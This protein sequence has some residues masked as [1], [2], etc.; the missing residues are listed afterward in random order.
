[1]LRRRLP[2]LDQVGDVADRVQLLHRLGIYAGMNLVGDSAS[3]NVIAFGF[4]EAWELNPSGAGSWTQ[5]T[6][7]RAPPDGLL[8]PNVPPNSL[9]SCDV[10][11]FG[12]VVYIDGLRT[13]KPKC[14]MW[15][16]KSARAGVNVAAA[17]NYQGQWWNAPAGSEAGWGINFAHQGDVIFATWFTHDANGNAWYMSM[18]AVETGAGTFAGTLYQTTGPRLDA[19]SFDPNQVQRIEVGNGTLAFSDGNNGTFD[20][21]VNGI[22]QTKPITRQVFGPV[23]TCTWAG[24]ANPALATNYQDLWWA[25][26]GVE[27]GWGIN[28][29]HQGDVIFATWFTYDFNGAALPLSATL[30]KVGPGVYSGTL[31]KTAGPPFSSV[32]FDSSAVTR[33]EVGTA[34]V[35][36]SN[37]DAATFSYQV[38]LGGQSASGTRAIERQVFRAPG[39]VCQ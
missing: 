12:V 37:G 33:A 30:T 35:T 11:S 15:V 9:I 39:T 38:S 31:L 29:A 17:P 26:G 5:M 13:R 7:S 23:P 25:V 8:S 19:N 3:G 10:T 22:S 24:L 14:R 20:Y 27:S 36:F 32:P 28:F 21:T 1:V 18:T 6:G 34:T 4:G 2:D 16:Y